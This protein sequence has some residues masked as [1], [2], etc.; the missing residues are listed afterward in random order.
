MRLLHTPTVTDDWPPAAAGCM[1]TAPLCSTACTMNTVPGCLILKSRSCF[2]TRYNFHFTQMQFLQ[3]C[4]PSHQSSWQKWS[5]KFLLQR[6]LPRLSYPLS[7]LMILG[8]RSIP[9]YL[10]CK[11]PFN[12]LYTCFNS[13]TQSLMSMAAGYA[14][15]ISTGLEVMQQLLPYL[16][17]DPRKKLVKFPRP[18][19]SHFIL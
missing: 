16:S 12:K 19:D 6:T 15:W 1:Q 17:W 4:T 8:G 9:F 2:W 7:I 5:A 18:M 11:G 14:W 3:K 13:Y 10:V